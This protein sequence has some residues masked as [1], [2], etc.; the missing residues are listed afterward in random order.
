VI[1]WMFRVNRKRIDLFTPA[2]STTWNGPLLA[3][4]QTGSAGMDWIEALLR[5]SHGQTVWNNYG[6]P[7]RYTAQAKYICPVLL[8][9]PP[10]AR[11]IWVVGEGDIVAGPMSHRR[12]RFDRDAIQ[13]CAMDEWLAIEVWDES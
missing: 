12:S 6:Y 4:W 2:T 1:G 7:N 8:A 5:E 10:H 3:A 11:D 9:G 13:A